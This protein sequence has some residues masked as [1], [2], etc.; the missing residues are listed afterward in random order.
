MMINNYNIRLGVMKTRWIHLSPSMYLEPT[1]LLA[2]LTLLLRE[3]EV[4]LRR[5][6]TRVAR[7]FR[8]LYPPELLSDQHVFSL[9]RWGERLKDIEIVDRIVASLHVPLPVLPT[10]FHTTKPPIPPPVANFQILA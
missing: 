5:I 6:A 7:R 4:G 9:S 1:L 3:R 10:T 2:L 8:P